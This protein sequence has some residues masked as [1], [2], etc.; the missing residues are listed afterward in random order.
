M[1]ASKSVNNVLSPLL[2]STPFPFRPEIKTL[3]L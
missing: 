2:Q 1:N 3:A